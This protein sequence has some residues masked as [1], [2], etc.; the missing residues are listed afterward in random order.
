MKTGFFCIVLCLALGAHAEPSRSTFEASQWSIPESRIDALVQDSL[1]ASDLSMAAPCSDAVF[2]RRLWLDLCGTL[3]DRQGVEAFLSDASLDKRIRII[4]TF[5]GSEAYVDFITLRWCDLLRVKSEYPVN[6]W[7]NA[8]QAYHRWVK[9]AVVENRPYDRFARELLTGTGSNFRVPAA[10]FYRVAPTKSPSDLAGVVS[11]TFMGQPLDSLGDGA[12]TD[13]AGFFAA[14]GFK[15]TQEWKEEIVYWNGSAS[16]ETEYRLPDGTALRLPSRED[17]REPLAKWMTAEANPWFAACVVN[18]L[19][20][21]FNGYGLYEDA[22]D[23]SSPCLNADL[24]AYL[25]GELVSSGYDLQHVSRLILSSRTY[26]QSCLP[27]GDSV[28]SPFASYQVRP[29]E[30]EVL[31]DALH[32]LIGISFL[33]TSPIPEPFTFIPPDTRTIALAD[34]SIT[35][36]FLETFGRPS[37]DSGKLGERSVEASAAQRL[38]LLNSEDMHSHLTARRL[39]DL[40]GAVGRS[41]VEWTDALYLSILSREPS[42][43]ERQEFLSLFRE[44]KGQGRRAFVDLA[45]ALINSKE[46]QFK[47]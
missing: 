26:Q 29:M 46:F 9:E 5:M 23:I 6:L 21:W 17:A 36:P 4:D 37:R 15:R 25:S 40:V 44:Q 12:A 30:A 2:L 22:D 31:A 45:W 14:L 8:V 19:W 16:G 39:A 24:V 35:S 27:R 47:H 38:Y 10:N 43:E 13:L 42:R 34:G 41:P 20:Y 11:F 7:P 3:P 18:R 33:Y 1:A 28:S 32:Q